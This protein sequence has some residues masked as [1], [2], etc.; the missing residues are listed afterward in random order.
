[1]YKNIKQNSKNMDHIRTGVYHLAYLL[2][3]CEEDFLK[4]GFGR[5]KLSVETGEDREAGK[6]TMISGEL[7]KLVR[8]QIHQGK[9]LTDDRNYSKQ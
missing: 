5:R 2:M 7:Q 6:A 3:D 1:M 8:L 4:S 9:Q